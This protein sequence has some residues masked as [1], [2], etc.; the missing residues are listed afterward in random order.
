M[1]GAFLS[2]RNVLP[3]T[4]PL[5]GEVEAYLA[6]EHRLGRVLD[7]G[8]IAPRIQALYDWSARELAIPGLRGLIRHGN[9]IYAFPY[10]ERH[11]WTQPPDSPA[12]R[13]IRRATS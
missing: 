2:L 9:P 3:N 8:V 12:L 6:Q 11:V 1:A 5:G 13:V 7:Y 10:E 4:Y